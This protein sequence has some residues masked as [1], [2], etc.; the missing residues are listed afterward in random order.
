M[1]VLY[2]KVMVKTLDAP[3]NTWVTA[4]WLPK[5][6]RGSKMEVGK[7]TNTNKDSSQIKF[8]FEK[9]IE[10]EE[11]QFEKVVEELC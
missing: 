4:N 9:V 1:Y 11:F 6:G 7:S 3:I 2:S 10:D 5:S 8:L